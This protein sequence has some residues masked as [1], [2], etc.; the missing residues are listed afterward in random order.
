MENFEKI[1]SQCIE[2]SNEN[3]IQMPSLPRQ[4]R[5]L[6]KLQVSLPEPLNFDSIEK[7]INHFTTQFLIQQLK[8]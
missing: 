2:F 8:I 6:N 3:Q 1:Y 7:S 4:R 5:L